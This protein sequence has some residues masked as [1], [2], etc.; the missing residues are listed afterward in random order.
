[1]RSA[2]PLAL[3]AAAAIFCAVGCGALASD[4]LGLAGIHNFHRATTNVF[5]GAQPEGEAAF[6][7]L[8]GLR[9]KTILSV[10]GAKPDVVLAAKHGLRY[11]HLPI[12]YDG[13]TSSRIAELAQA[14]A[15]L[16]GPIFVHCHHGLHR[17]PAAAAILCRAS[18]GWNA[19]EAEDFMKRA[20]TAP[21]YSG[22]YRGV[23]EFMPPSPAQLAA[24]GTNFSTVAKTTSLVDAMV[25]IDAHFD[26]LDSSD[27]A[28]WK[29]A[30][31]AA[32]GASAR[33]ALLLLEQLRELARTSDTKQRPADYRAKL[34]ESCAAAEK[35]HAQLT[36]GMPVAEAFTRVSHSC[37]DCHRRYRNE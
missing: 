7:A 37:A 20:G 29:P 32:S 23:R 1:M 18:A 5:S 6:A 19:D 27:R 22:L 13:I 30:P 9:V 28:G 35:L 16:P 21:E 8:A 34:N 17:G 14:A 33:E 10:D 15:T 24:V 25:A 4:G 11:V 36:A 26:R 2:R 3:L 12:G 31:T